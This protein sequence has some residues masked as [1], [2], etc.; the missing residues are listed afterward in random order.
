M[1]LFPAS[2]PDGER[3]ATLL[4]RVLGIFFGLAVAAFAVGVLSIVALRSTAS[5][6]QDTLL[7]DD[8][9]LIALQALRTES[10]HAM[11]RARGY[12]GSADERAHAAVLAGRLRIDE[13][14]ARV[15]DFAPE[16]DLAAL[17]V[18]SAI[19]EAI[20]EETDRLAAER[21]AGAP[22]DEARARAA[23]MLQP[24]QHRL[25]R[26]ISN[27]TARHQEVHA[28]RHRA[29]ALTASRA[30]L[31]VSGLT[32][33]TA[34]WAVFLGVLQ[35]R[36]LRGQGRT[37]RALSA[38]E[39]RQRFLAES[40]A[41]LAESLDADE[42]LRRVS[43]LVVPH[44]AD[45]CVISLRDPQAPG[46]HRLAAARHR[47]PSKLEELLAA[48]RTLAQKPESMQGV[49]I[50]M[51][52]G[53]TS[54]MSDVPPP[55]VID[56]LGGGMREEHRELLRLF[57]VRSFVAAPFRARGQVLG[58]FALAQLEGERRFNADDVSMIEE[59]VHRASLSLDN[60]ILYADAQ[61]TAEQLRRLQDVTAA[62]ARAS[63]ADEVVEAFSRAGLAR[64]GAAH[65]AVGRIR[66]GAL[67]S[68]SAFGYPDE[69]ITL[70]KNIPLVELPPLER[71]VRARRALWFES[72]DE[73]S[74]MFPDF[75]PMNAGQPRSGGDIPLEGARAVLPLVTEDAEL[76][77]AWLTW[78]EPRKF[79][80]EE[81]QFLESLSLR[82]TQALERAVLVE[83]RADAE[84]RYR[85]ATRATKD[86][87]WDLDLRTDKIVWNEGLLELF[88]WDP[89]EVEADL[90]WW[91]VNVHDDERERVVTGIDAAVQSGEVDWHDEYL[92][93][94]ADGSW[95]RVTDRGF[96]VHD[97][98]GSP[99]RMVGSMQDVTAERRAT[100][101]LRLSE[102]RFR[103]FVEATNQ[104]IWQTDAR[105]RVERDLPT[106]RA[107]TGQTVEEMM[108]HG[109]LRA[110]HPDDV[111]RFSLHPPWPRPRDGIQEDEVRIR[112]SD[113]E[114][115]RVLARAVPIVDGEV[116]REWIGSAVDVTE[117]RE[118]ERQANLARTIAE[119]AT[120]ALFFLDDDAR[121]TFM[122]P[123]AEEMCGWSFEQARG[124]RLSDIV[125]AARPEL[126]D[127]A[128]HSR[129]QLRGEDVFVR[130]DGST[131]PVELAASPIL[132]DGV[133]HGTVVEVWDT[134]D[135]EKAKQERE[136]MLEREMEARADAE[137]ANRLKDEFLATISHELRT[138]LMAVLG[139]V[140]MLRRAP[141][142][143]D[144]QEHA[145][146][147]IER[148]ARAQG[149]LIDDLLD[150]SRIMSGK[151]RLEVQPVMMA[152]V[153]EGALGSAAP[154][155]EVKGV[156]IDAA[157]GADLP[158]VLG[159]ATRL[160]QV[161]WNLLSNAVKFT[162][163]GGVIAVS[164]R[165]RGD[166]FEV[167]VA[168][169]G[170]GIAPALLPH[171]FERFRQADGT[172][173][174]RH[175][176][177]GLGLAIVKHI[178]ELHGGWVE[179]SSAGEGHGASFRVFLP[180]GAAARRTTVA[181]AQAE[182]V[183]PEAVAEVL[184]APPGLEGL[185]VLVV[186][187]EPDT[188][189]VLKAMLEEGHAH[190]YVAQ[191][192]AAGLEV[193]RR[194]HPDVLLSDIG[195]PGEDGYAFIHKVRALDAGAG[196]QVPAIALTAYGRPDDRARAYA[197]G[198]NVHLQKPV[199]PQE[200]LFTVASAAGRA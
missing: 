67:R 84:T 3:T 138:P 37:V 129:E 150:V 103:S 106:W 157:I 167:E 14:L 168:D 125:R 60:A 40:S 29:A 47:D 99:V 144:K 182:K 43:E 179:A 141:M 90:A 133:P 153:I 190:V 164:T 158:P 148:N 32:L 169:T 117:R 104:I 23:M 91:G 45:L 191:S 184:A 63:S 77:V 89:D 30:A 165:V 10:E 124:R 64:V 17:D 97:E 49:Q 88:G 18:I 143:A 56:A 82:C 57:P 22:T 166:V 81:K 139:W 198:F 33:L 15:Y 121:C 140:Q 145:L 181:A 162:P 170:Q 194:E 180:L 54:W 132:E 146:E 196:G 171:V 34:A 61:R 122:N 74:A 62:F 26:E 136:L 27:L 156:R 85:L 108:G 70:F 46:G 41:A 78:S 35:A 109:W 9:Q 187:D 113:G 128:A 120:A 147:I 112:R 115:R 151:L 110:V 19:L 197:A 80:D 172:V 186:D 83:M 135:V 53:A 100:E 16:E 200:L 176:G 195:M 192:A 58:M 94:R 185:R 59:L 160:Q 134:T 98:E 142:A 21:M 55:A 130:A 44:L 123:S 76:G 6:M 5:T 8:E 199:A 31:A 66:D 52:E 87:V 69:D 73:F 2:P 12:I 25:D 11:G 101:A 79:A 116:V 149:K 188:R 107:F 38:A 152:Q 20:D 119:N 68:M 114:W 1:A 75:A 105:G 28:E 24:L 36:A 96:I 51:N 65:G 92:F 189:E 39:V 71:A 183:G 131:Y 161:V 48:E 126:L 173:A 50:A 95:A 175:G 4:R 42:V 118:A 102:E 163:A 159:D 137:A 13:A 155:A 127:E 193:L 72:Y 174:R 7:V 177:L 178:V 86:A 154:A 93:R 111:L